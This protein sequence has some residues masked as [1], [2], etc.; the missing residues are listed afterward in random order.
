MYAGYAEGYNRPELQW[1]ASITKIIGAFNLSLQLKDILNQTR[2][3]S[4]TITA[5]YQEDTYRLM[6]GRYFLIG[7]KWNFG[8]MNAQHSQR[9]QSAAFNMF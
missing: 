9:A 8:K 2:N 5:D 7:V 3:L 6:M 4:H 1:D